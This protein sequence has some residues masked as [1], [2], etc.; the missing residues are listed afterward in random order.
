[1]NLNVGVNNKKK[2]KNLRKA[3]K[4]PKCSYSNYYSYKYDLNPSCNNA[5]KNTNSMAH[6]KRENQESYVSQMMHCNKY[7]TLALVGAGISLGAIGIYMLK[8]MY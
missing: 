2:I 8:K 4:F 6:N 3:T 1:M 5:Q 7:K